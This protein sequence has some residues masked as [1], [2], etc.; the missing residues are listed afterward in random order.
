MAWI[1]NLDLNFLDV[2]INLLIRIVVLGGLVYLLFALRDVRLL[3]GVLHS[4]GYCHRIETAE[5]EWKPVEQFMVEFSEAML[6]HGV[7]PE[8]ANKHWG[9]L[10]KVVTKR[11]S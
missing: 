5:G 6:S 1:W 10:S 9:S 11:K 7:C 3:R 2:M 8:C 4:C